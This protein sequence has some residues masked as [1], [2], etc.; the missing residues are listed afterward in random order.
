MDYISVKLLP[1]QKAEVVIL[2]S[3]KVDFRKKKL[4]LQRNITM[5]KKRSIHQKNIMIL[6]VYISKKKKKKS[7][8][9]LEA[10]TA[11][12]GETEKSTLY[13]E[14]PIPLLA[15][16]RTRQKI[17]RKIEELNNTTSSI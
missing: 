17:S 14:L 7:F 4:P 9:I 10:E 2:I 15:T 12:K 6:N 13:L 5:I 8:Q 3:N 11:L 1:R 16:N